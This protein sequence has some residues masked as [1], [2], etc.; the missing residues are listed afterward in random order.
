MKWRLFPRRA[1]TCPV[2]SVQSLLGRWLPTC[3]E[4]RGKSRFSEEQTV[5]ILREAE[6]AVPLLRRV[7][8]ITEHD[9]TPV[10]ET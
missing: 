4:P 8:S 2:S 5:A 10:A 7:L 3:E 6:R 9:A 1:V